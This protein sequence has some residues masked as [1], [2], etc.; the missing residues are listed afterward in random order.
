MLYTEAY[1]SKKWYRW[2]CY[3][4]TSFNPFYWCYTPFLA[5]Q[6]TKIK[7]FI[8]V[9]GGRGGAPF[10][11]GVF[12]ADGFFFL[13]FLFLSLLI[14]TRLFLCVLTCFCIHVLFFHWS[15]TPH[16]IWICSVWCILCVKYYLFLSSVLVQVCISLYDPR[17]LWPWGPIF[18]Y[19]VL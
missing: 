18:Y 9:F 16:C 14:C 13:P 7:S 5:A 10:C 15:A 8:A 19:P 17:V 11:P 1:P 4:L 12:Y 3:T 6:I 2:N